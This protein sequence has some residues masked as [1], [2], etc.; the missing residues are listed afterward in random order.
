MNYKP[1]SAA[2]LTLLCGI[3]LWPATA[4]YANDTLM[5]V[6]KQYQ[7]RGYD[8]YQGRIGK[9]S[10]L[11]LNADSTFIFQVKRTS[12]YNI[13]QLKSEQLDTVG[14]C[15]GTYALLDTTLRMYC[16]SCANVPDTLTYGFTLFVHNLADTLTPL[17]IPAQLKL[18]ADSTTSGPL[19]KNLMLNKYG[20]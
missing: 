16:D 1:F 7:H 19:G 14:T 15:G 3:L 18:V 17:S 11:K 4:A 20:R 12:N 2:I 9:V 13:Q 8:A 6:W 10:I 5:G